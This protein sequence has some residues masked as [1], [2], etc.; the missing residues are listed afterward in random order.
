MFSVENG[1]GNSE[2]FNCSSCEYHTECLLCLALDTRR[3]LTDRIIE[4]TE[5]EKCERVQLVR[6]G[7]GCPGS[8]GIVWIIKHTR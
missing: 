5:R 8:L 7:Q 3:L 6:E 1:Y 4:E 2:K